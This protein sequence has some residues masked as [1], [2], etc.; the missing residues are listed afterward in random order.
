MKVYV[1]FFIK[2]IGPEKPKGG[3]AWRCSF[4]GKKGVHGIER[5]LKVSC[6]N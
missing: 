4:E 2:K 1:E 3:D 5:E 6:F